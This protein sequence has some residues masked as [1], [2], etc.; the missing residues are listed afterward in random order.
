MDLFKQILPS[1]LEKNEYVYDDYDSSSYNPY[2]VDIALSAHIDCLP[3]LCELN[4]YPILSKKMHYDYLFY[5]IR[6]YKRPFQ[7]WVK[8]T[9]PD[10]L[11]IIME[12]YNYSK[13]KALEVLDILSDEQM[14][15][16]K[17]QLDKGG[18]I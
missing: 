17:Q 14:E 16:I 11:S 2:I 18:K 13:D 9:E 3:Y 4:Q 5:S 15:Y 1:I 7:K 6:K 8:Y 12:Y 10:N